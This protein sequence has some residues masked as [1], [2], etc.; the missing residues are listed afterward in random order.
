MTTIGLVRHGITDWNEL[1]KSQGIS[2][3][4]L[5]NLGK[6][7]AIALANRLVLEGEWDVIV[8]SDL[9]RAKE[10]GQII[11][12][13]L[14][15]PINIYDK[16]IREINCGEIEGTTEEERLKR[17]G[18]NWWKLD[19]GMEKFGDVSNRGY[20]FLTELA[21]TYSDKR[22]LVV[23]HGALIGLTLQRLLPEQF[24]KTQLDNTS[25]TILTIK[26]GIWNCSLYN[27]TKHL[28]NTFSNV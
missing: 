19:L 13:K 15:L 5:N 24:Q 17:W 20:E 7:Q 12:A 11:A 9:S 18:S 1:G 28:D 21:I 23:S 10:T 22:V 16:R 2:D 27:C 4:P 14:N 3:I 25:L 8:T 26:Q 6:L